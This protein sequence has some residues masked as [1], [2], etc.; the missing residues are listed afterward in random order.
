M[1]EMAVITNTFHKKSVVWMNWES[2][3]KMTS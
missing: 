1:Q 2:K 3:I